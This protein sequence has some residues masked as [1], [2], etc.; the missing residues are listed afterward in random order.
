MVKRFLHNEVQ[1]AKI[2]VYKMAT[3]RKC[4]NNN[5]ILNESSI[6]IKDIT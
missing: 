1:L 4:S 2:I 3:L 5:G 6:Y